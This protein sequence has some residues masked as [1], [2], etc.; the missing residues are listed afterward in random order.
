MVKRG[1]CDLWRSL[2]GNS[3]PR[4]RETANNLSFN[5]SGYTISGST[6]TL[7]GGTVSVPSAGVAT[8]GSALS[9]PSG[10]NL[11]SSGGTLV[12]N[13]AVSLVGGS[14][15][16]VNVPS[17]SLVLGQA[18]TLNIPNGGTLNGNL[19]IARSIRVNFN[20]QVGSTSSALP[21]VAAYSGSGSIQ[22]Q[23][24]TA[25]LSNT[26]GT[27]GGAIGTPGGGLQI[28]LNSSSLG[29]SPFDV[30]KASPAYP[31]N[32]FTVAIG[33]DEKRQLQWVSANQR[34]RF[35]EFR[36]GFHL[37]FG[38]RGRGAG[39]TLLNAQCNYTGTTLIEGNGGVTAGYN[40]GSLILGVSNAL[41]TGTDVEFG[42]INGKPSHNPKIDLGGLNQQI[43]S[44]SSNAA[45]L[46]YSPTDT[47][48]IANNVANTVATLTV[49]G[50]NTPSN[51]Y[52]GF[53]VDNSTGSGG[54]L[55]LVKDGT[56]TLTL[57]NSNAYSGGTTI[58]NGILSVANTSTTTSA[59]GSGTVDV[60]GGALP[61][62]RLAAAL[63]ASSRSKAAAPCFPAA[64]RRLAANRLRSR[65][66]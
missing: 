57:S 51:A 12:L 49:S 66:V 47:F 8:I 3:I 39:V 64:G 9:I 13:G 20:S 38:D 53:I 63:P 30:T 10:D 14:S 26:S 35:R 62:R 46:T 65:A 56:N 54:T 59:L 33:A 32:S 58:R 15:T 23:S 22:V 37:E 45:S 50:N 41:P 17:G 48:Y 19:V 6:L 24:S 42:D 40:G 18:S 5:R 29:F 2:V 4:S 52:G 43:G 21:N 7:T 34:D 36:R 31:A 55:A 25:I 11:T 27:Y 61:V 28:L 44:L 16:T 1:Q 60:Q